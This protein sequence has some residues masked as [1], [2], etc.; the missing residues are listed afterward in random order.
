MFSKRRFRRRNKPRSQHFLEGGE[1][2]NDA[3]F[4]PPVQT[5]LNIG[6]P[7]DIYEKEA[8]KTA[9][10]VVAK[11]NSTD[12]IQKMGAEEEEVQTKPLAAGLTPFVQRQESPEEEEPVQAMAEEKEEESIQ[13]QEEEEESLQTKCDSCANEDKL[14]KM[15]GEEEEEALQTKKNDGGT[16][17]T[18]LTSQLQASKASGN[19]MDKTSRVEMEHAFGN[20][21]SQVQIHTDSQAKIMNKHLNAQAFTHGN[22]IYFN[23]GKYDPNSKKGKHLL[24]HELTHTIQQGASAE[25]I[26]PKLRVEDDYPTDYV[27]KFQSVFNV[28]DPKGKDPSIALSKKDRLD[29]VTKQLDKLSP[30]FT[31]DASGNVNPSGT[32][33]VE[34]T[35]DDTATASCCMHV[36]TRA[37]SK[38]WQILVAD[39]LAP[40]TLEQE[41][42]VLINSNLNPIKFGAHDKAGNKF[43]YESN[44]ELIL[45]HE[46]CGHAALMEIG[47][48]AEGKRAV[49]NVHDSTINIENEIAK[50]LGKRENQ[51]RGLA[52]DGPHK[53]ESFG[54]TEVIDFDF[55]HSNIK[56][57]GKERLKL[58]ADMIRTHDLFVEI[59]GHSDNVG[60]EGAKQNISD[61]RAKTVFLL[62]RKLGV[63]L[64]AGVNIDDGPDVKVNRWLLKGMSDKEPLKGIDLATEQHKLRRVDVFVSSF[65]AGLSELPPGIP[66]G[67]IEK[68]KKFDQ[69]EEP[70]KVQENIDSGTPC[71]KWLSEKAYRQP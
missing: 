25:T 50:S 35:E 63:P 58:L 3:P 65:P 57:E 12:A 16:N 27:K 68:L 13:M 2:Q 29:L 52:S 67:V 37:G 17:A 1:Q 4:I 49:T 40:H 36:L 66:N 70:S 7:G 69:V 44:P 62:L 21:F 19:P 26:Q 61:R 28:N 60:S 32:G 56:P 33:E 45:G 24:A 22:H 8:D 64:N 10:A 18:G 42:N 38:D 5:K 46:L 6:K 34:L 11:T 15:E 14:Q 9:D 71:E 47:A 41:G 54:H 53:G 23:S 43:S 39:H 59:R 30:H 31:T 20:D 48:H 51:L 55:G